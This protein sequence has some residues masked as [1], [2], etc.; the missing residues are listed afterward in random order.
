MRQTPYTIWPLNLGTAGSV[1]IRGPWAQ[2]AF[3]EARNAGAYVTARVTVRAGLSAEDAVPMRPG[4]IFRNLDTDIFVVEW[5]AQ[6][7]VTATLG[8]TNR[9][10]QVDWQI[11]PVSP[12]ATIAGT[13]DTRMRRR[14]A[15]TIYA[16][17][18]SVG[19]GGAAIFG[20]A[21]DRYRCDATVKNIGAATVYIGASDV[22]PTSGFELL[23]GESITFEDVSFALYGMTAAGTTTVSVAIVYTNV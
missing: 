11:P 14:V 8:L 15:T 5:E 3:L 17:Q 18:A 22:L 2:I 12:P 1:A 21:P 13:V 6:S 10:E 23:S 9:P 19:T 16:S 7:G 20:A 4:T